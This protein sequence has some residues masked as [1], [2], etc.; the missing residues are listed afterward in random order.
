VDKRLAEVVDQQ[1]GGSR[2]RLEAHVKEAGLR[3]E[4]F[5]GLIKRDMVVQQYMREKLMPR[6]QVTRAELMAYYHRHRG[7]YET[8]ETRELLLMEFPYAA[9]LP[10]GVAWERASRMQQGQAKLAAMRAARAAE[11]A[12]EERPFGDVARELGR[13]LQRYNGGSWGMIGRPLEAPYNEVSK[14]I[15]EYEEGQRSAPIETDTGYYIVQC[16]AVQA[17]ENRSF[18]DV[19]DEIRNKLRSDRFARLSAEYVMRLAEDATVSSLE[20]ATVSSLELFI[21]AAVRQAMQLPE[22]T[23]ANSE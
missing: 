13:G 6:I 9:Y 12:L 2:A 22:A 8:P 23:A 16:G 5:R 17:A 21:N 20:H 14:L 15:F 11:E 19:Q 18:V 3:M 1:F 4:Q 10:D 7:E